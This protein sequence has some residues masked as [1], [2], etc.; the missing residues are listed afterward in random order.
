MDEQHRRALC[1]A[2]ARVADAQTVELDK[3][4]GRAG[5]CSVV[6][7]G[8]GHHVGGNVG[9]DVGIADIGF[10]HHAK[11][12][13]HRQQFTFTGHLAPQQ[14]GIG[15]FDRVGNLVGFHVQD[16][17]AHRDAC[18]WFD[19][20]AAHGAFLHRKTPLGHDDGGDAGHH[21]FPPLRVRRTASATCAADQAP[22]LGDT[23]QHG[24]DVQRRQ[25]A[26]VHNFHLDALPGQRGGGIERAVHHQAIGDDRAVLAFAHHVGF[27]QRNGVRAL[28][29]FAFHGV[30]VFVLAK[31]HR[32][33]VP[34]RLDQQALGVVRRAWA[35]HL[36]PRNVREQRREHLAVLR[37]RAKT[38]TDHGADH[39]RR[40]GLAAKHVAEFGRLVEDLVKA[41]A[42][43]VDE[44]QL[45]NRA[46][47]A[48]RSAD[49]RA[50]VGALG[51]RGVKQPVA[52]FGVQALGNAEHA[53][54][55]VFF[56]LAAGAAHDVFAHHDH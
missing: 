47:A 25:G 9:I 37:C 50:H 32:V 22:G 6:C 11:Q 31:N 24:V 5:I 53:A 26:Q 21:C 15:R 35:H 20:P 18:A 45:G 4:V 23:L 3:L 17:H 2:T 38:G 7:V 34:D 41:H 43:E 29:H 27:S 14:T 54:P 28:G 10:G 55:G 12:R 51:Q 42:H 52:M 48:G 44:H 13:F 46:H 36:E 1:C 16:R 33:V 40:F 49:G 30:K 19:Q 39:H 8:C 56:A